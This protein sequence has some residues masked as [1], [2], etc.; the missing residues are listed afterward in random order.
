MYV[1]Y[2]S[3][4]PVGLVCEAT[5]LLLYVCPFYVCPHT[6]LQTCSNNLPYLVAFLYVSAYG[7]CILV[8]EL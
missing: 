3:R 6:I 4:V 8:D 7:L 1:L 2:V 5:K